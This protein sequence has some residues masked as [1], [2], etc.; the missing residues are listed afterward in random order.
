MAW[1]DLFPVLIQL[2][3]VHVVDNKRDS[4]QWKDGDSVSEVSASNI[5]N[6]VRYSD[7]EVGWSK[8]VWCAHCIP[9][10]AFLL[11]LIM[12]KKL[13][14]QDIIL[15]W[16]LSRRKNMNMMCCLLCY[17]NHDSHEHLFF[18]C[19][20]SAKIWNNVRQKAGMY[21]VAPKWEEI[22]EWLLDRASSK[23]ASNYV[24]R[25]LVAAT[26]YFIWQERNAKLFKNQVRPPDQLCQ[27]IINIVRYKLMGVR[28]KRNDN[29]LKLL[30][31]WEIQDGDRSD[32][33]G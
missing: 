28:L 10:H 14:T 32:D 5:W 7:L 29:V 24:S 2:D 27:I 20:Y 13:L 16:D 26:A 18:E 23:S 15:Q 19:K 8:I 6:T 25:I 12:R 31:E 21:D 9:R 3:Q 11:W 17:E 22:V 4:I 30:R 1:R 33:G